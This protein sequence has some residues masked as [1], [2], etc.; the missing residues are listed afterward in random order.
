MLDDFSL[1]ALVSYAEAHPVIATLL[2]LVAVVLLGSLLRKIFKV[3]V[4]CAIVLLVGLY[5]TQGDDP[6]WWKRVEVIGSEVVAWGEAFLEKADEIFEKGK[7][8]L[9]GN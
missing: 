5:F 7:E 2:L 9:K 8:Q 3:A 4:V 6:D 1:E